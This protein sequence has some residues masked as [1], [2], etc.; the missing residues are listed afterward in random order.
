MSRTG[1]PACRDVRASALA[2]PLYLNLKR[3]GYLPFK[4]SMV[5]RVRKLARLDRQGRL[6]YS[7]RI[8]EHS[9]QANGYTENALSE[10]YRG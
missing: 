2:P 6:S 10:R 1:V 4:A 7:E 8:Q 9:F 3:Q 5:A